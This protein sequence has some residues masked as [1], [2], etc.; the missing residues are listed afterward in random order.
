M[1]IRMSPQFFALIG[2]IVKVSK[3]KETLF[4]KADGQ[5]RIGIPNNTTFIHLTAS[6][7]DF[8]F[9]DDTVN[10]SSLAEF[11]TYANLVG[12][13]EKG[14]AHLEQ[15]MSRAGRPYEYITFKTNGTLAHASTIART[16]TAD[17]TCFTPLDRKVPCEREKDPMKLLYTIAM[18]AKQL[19]DVCDR[20][21]KVPGCEYVNTVSDGEVVKL[22]FKGKV[23]QQI[24]YILDNTSTMINDEA[25]I[26]AA[27]MNN[28]FRMFSAS[29]FSLLKGIGC[30]FVTEAR[31]AKN[32]KK[33]VMSLKSFADIPGVNEGF[34]IKIYAI[35]MESAASSI[36]NYDLVD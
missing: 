2:S 4:F 35:A 1:E 30:D 34:P 36:S 18:G 21:K 33:D 20:M 19:K 29:Y 13:P 17:P 22:Y 16:I 31:Y 7:D 25:S 11:I 32:P 3:S 15:V 14:C 5:C 26:T 9:D 12:Y 6:P 27:Y 10:V 28:E 8:W 23:G 24:T